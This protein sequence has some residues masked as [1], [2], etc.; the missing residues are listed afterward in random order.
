M[1][2]ESGIQKNKARVE[3]R[4]KWEA[5]NSK[6]SMMA[7]LRL[8]EFK[9]TRQSALFLYPPRFAIVKFTP[10]NRAMLEMKPDLLMSLMSVSCTSDSMH[11]APFGEIGQ[12]PSGE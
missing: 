4:E 8:L 9:D 7:E 1:V 6:P 3:L 2:L 5:E 11:S 12:F 10:P